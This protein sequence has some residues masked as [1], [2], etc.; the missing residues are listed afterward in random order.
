[1]ARR[2][3][4]SAHPLPPSVPLTTVAARAA[5]DLKADKL[6]VMTTPDSQP[7]H[8]PLWL[9]LSDA[10]A[11]LRRMAP[12][13]DHAGLLDSDLQRGGR[14]VVMDGCMPRKMHGGGGVQSRIVPCWTATSSEV[15]WGP[16]H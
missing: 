4:L 3:A 13:G 6:I 16:A 9:P 12:E 2:L 1:M 8:L 7:L 10:E 14:V 5:I 15:G 11:M